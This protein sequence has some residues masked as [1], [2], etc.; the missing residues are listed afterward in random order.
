MKFGDYKLRPQNGF[1]LI[2]ILVGMAL[3][4][5]LI[6][7]IVVTIFQVNIGTAQNE[8]SMYVLRQVQTAG[9]Y[10]SKDTLQA[11]CIGLGVDDGFP[12][13]LSWYDPGAS[14]N[15]S[16]KYEYDSN[17]RYL[18][19]IDLINNSTTRIADSIDST[20]S[21]TENSTGYFILTVTASTSG[22]QAASATRTY[23]IESRFGGTGNTTGS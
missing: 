7:G 20:I 10:I 14:E 11:K 15:H 13:T 6:T 9:Y 1:T 23:E 19:R 12:V 21:F 17:T 4:G 3:T 22:Y 18:T 16:I 2:E 8:N 5:I